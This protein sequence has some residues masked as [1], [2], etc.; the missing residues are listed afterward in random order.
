MPVQMPEADAEVLGRR[1]EILQALRAIVPGEGVIASE[2][3]LRVLRVE[4]AL[5]AYRQLPMLVVLPET[6][7]QVSRG[8]A[9]LPCPRA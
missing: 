6:T 5:T 8:P 9:P 1:N 4:M 3:E 2:A 7:E